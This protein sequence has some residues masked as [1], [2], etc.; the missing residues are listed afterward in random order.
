VVKINYPPFLIDLTLHA[1]V[2]PSKHHAK[3]KRGVLVLELRKVN[4]CM[5]AD[6]SIHSKGAA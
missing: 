3:V 5:V 2:D 6:I 4:I 1:S